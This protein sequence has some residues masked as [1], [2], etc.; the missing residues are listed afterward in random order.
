MLRICAFLMKDGILWC[1]MAQKMRNVLKVYLVGGAVRDQLLGLPV[2]ERDW[3]VVGSTPEEMISLGFRPVGKEFP[4]FL[5][6]KTQEEYALARTEKKI[7]KGY[8]GFTFYTSPEVTL[9]EDLI[10]R[11]LTVNAMAQTEQG[12]LVDPF[13]GQ[14]DLQQKILRHVSSAFAEDPV[15]ILRA[16]RFAAKLQGFQVAEETNQLMRQMVDAGEVDALVAERVWQEFERALKLDQPQRFFEV[17]A[18]CNALANLFPE[19]SLQGKGILALQSAAQQNALP[20]IRFAALLHD[21]SLQSLQKMSARLKAPRDYAELAKV[22]VQWFSAY[23]QLV[24]ASAEEILTLLKSVDAIRRPE[25]FQQFVE[26][27]EICFQLE[28]K[29]DFASKKILMKAFQAMQNVDIQALLQQGLVGQALG[30]A[31]LDLQ[32]QEIQKALQRL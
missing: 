8:K 9:E 26:I 16:A 13:G 7:S 5:H 23:Q 15:R 18:E 17:L 29:Y 10:R 3:V 22:T 30:A 20:V 31:I 21:I 19:I 24:N 14:S 12:E 25:R 28:N 32:R 6:P 27:C 1:I 2:T 4:V 11:D